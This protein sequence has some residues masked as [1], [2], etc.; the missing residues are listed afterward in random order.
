MVLGFLKIQVIKELTNSSV[1]F[2]FNVSN[3]ISPFFASSHT[4]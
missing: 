3:E 2:G 4:N 1:L